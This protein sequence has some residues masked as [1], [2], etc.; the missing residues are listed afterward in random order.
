[1]VVIPQSRQALSRR[2][3]SWAVSA[4]SS[5]SRQV[6]KTMRENSGPLGA[7]RRRGIMEIWNVDAPERG[8]KVFSPIADIGPNGAPQASPELGATRRCKHL[9]DAQ[10]R[11]YASFR[12]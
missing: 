7:M 11:A 6:P 12:C 8:L 4:G 3:I 9:C 2:L 5:S 1:M 10:F